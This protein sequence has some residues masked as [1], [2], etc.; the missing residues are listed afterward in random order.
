MK[1]EL[2]M[3]GIYHFVPEHHEMVI[4][5][6]ILRRV[7]HWFL[8]EYN[9]ATL[10]EKRFYT[11]NARNL[12]YYT[13]NLTRTYKYPIMVEMVCVS[14]I[15]WSSVV[16]LETGCLNM[17]MMY[18]SEKDFLPILHRMNTFDH[19]AHLGVRSIRNPF[20]QYKK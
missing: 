6:K 9:T 7:G 14:T 20:K 5:D 18:R 17:N 12:L 3:N 15:G 10:S 4:L 11:F 1:K 13:Q 16:H 8:V 2:Y 19:W